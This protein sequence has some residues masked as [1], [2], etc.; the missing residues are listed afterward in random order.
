MQWMQWVW[1]VLGKDAA[2]A[3]ECGTEV[4]AEVCAV[5]GGTCAKRT[6]PEDIPTGTTGLA[7]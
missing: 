6:A 7:G 4:L 3:K 5:D 2:V 1:D